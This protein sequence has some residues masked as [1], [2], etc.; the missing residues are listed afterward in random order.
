MKKITSL[1]RK[2]RE[3]YFTEAAARKGVQP[4]IIEKDF[5]VC[6]TLKRLYEIKELKDNITF[7]GG[8][9][10]SKAYGII[11]R[12]SEDIDLTIAKPYLGVEGENDPAKATGTNKRNALLENLK[13][14]CGVA[15]GNQIL[16][17]LRQSFTEHLGEEDASFDMVGNT[18]KNHADG[19][20]LGIDD[21]DKQT[22][23]FGYPKAINY[24]LPYEQMEWEDKD[25]WLGKWGYIKPVIRLEF[26]AL[27]DSFPTE[28]KAIIPYLLQAI[29]ELGEE[30]TDTNVLS[31]ERTFWEKATILH[32]EAHRDQG[33]PMP[34][35]LSRHYYDLYM[36]AKAGIADKALKKPELLEVVAKH[37]AVFFPSAWASYDTAK[38]GSLKL[39]P[40]A[41]RIEE[42]KKD[43]KD[44]EPM[45]FTDAPSFDKVISYIGDLEKKI[46]NG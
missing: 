2:E 33:K 9:S 3:E 32:Q 24:V 4:I 40:P 27:G 38:K 29:P 17:L 39:L 26:G 8:T 34:S 20:G 37:K 44:M 46:N 13:E 14:R 25:F 43:Y 30:A 36:L 31:V 6:W 11:E 41:F 23:L 1:S 21:K 22:L 7:K 5:W 18:E 19:W 35:R 12:F 45:F 15:V 16:D 10:L 42:L 28:R